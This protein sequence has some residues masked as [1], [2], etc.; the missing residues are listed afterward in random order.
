MA[1]TNDSYIV[2]TATAGDI[3]VPIKEA[4]PYLNVQ[5]I[6]YQHYSYHSLMSQ[7]LANIVDDIKALQ[8]GG[9]AQATFDLDALIAQA[10]A[11]I[12]AQILGIESGINDK[13]I[14]QTDEAV[15]NTNIQLAAFNDTLNGDGVTTFG[16]VGDVSDAVAAIGDANSGLTKRV[17]TIETAVGDATSGG[18]VQQFNGIS[19][20]VTDLGIVVGSE[21]SGLV[22]DV[23]IIQDQLGNVSTGLIPRM[24][25]LE[26]TI[27]DAGSG[28]FQQVQTHDDVIYGDGTYA[29]LYNI[30]GNNT[31]GAIKAIE[32]NRL[33]IV[34]LDGNAKPRLTSIESALGHLTNTGITAD[35]ADLQ[36]AQATI[37]TNLGDTDASGLRLR[38]ANIEALNPQGIRNEIYG[39]GA[40]I[41]GLVSDTNGLRADVDS[42]LTYTSSGDNEA[43]IAAVNARVDTNVTNIGTNTTAIGTINGQI[44]TI[45]DNLN[46]VTTGINTQLANIGTTIQDTVLTYNDGLGTVVTFTPNVLY[47]IKTNSDALTT[48]DIVNQF[49]T[50]FGAPGSYIPASDVGK[51]ALD[52]W[53]ADVA[54]P[55]GYKLSAETI[56]ANYLTANYTMSNIA[57]NTAAITTLNG[58]VGTAGSVLHSIDTELT[59]YDDTLNGPTGSITILN[60]DIATPGSVD[61]T[62]DTAITAYDTQLQ[63]GSITTLQ[64]QINTLSTTDDEIKAEIKNTT[65]ELQVEMVRYDTILPFLQTMFKYVN[66]SGAITDSEIDSLFTTALGKVEAMAATIINQDYIIYF[67]DNG[68]GGLNTIDISVILDRDLKLTPIMGDPDG[69]YSKIRRTTDDFTNNGILDNTTLDAANNLVVESGIYLESL[70]ARVYENAA[71]LVGSEILNLTAPIV[72]EFATLDIF[73]QYKLHTVPVVARP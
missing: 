65:S 30:V 39:D 61:H 58:T 45:D 73:G 66:N 72:F 32:D 13:I 18:L 67:T 7:N 15:S 27:G 56:I 41:P 28:L 14:F 71:D 57:A 37:R 26:V 3:I 42:L 19:T 69:A 40:L 60:A 20:I 6:G 59:A 52:T 62:V 64:N 8:D 21:T 10:Q 53:I 35:V 55:T 31:T 34:A 9:L 54:N 50:Y 2:S 23:L 24:T 22:E 48:S 25:S 43:A 5:L 38:V 36:T 29:G 51:A 1:L 12:D 70:E 11:D 17:D 68:G 49:Q 33:A 47:A 4:V 46:N 44:T 63:A 16:I